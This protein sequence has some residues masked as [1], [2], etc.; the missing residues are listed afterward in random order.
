MAGLRLARSRPMSRLCTGSAFHRGFDP[1]FSRGYDPLMDPKSDRLKRGILVIAGSV[2][3]GIGI[4]GIFVPLLPTTPLLILAALCYMRGSQRLYNAL[5]G[6]RLAGSY[7][8]N[9]LEG[10]GMTLKMKIWTLT[11]L[12]VSLVLTA[13]LATGSWIIRI[14]LAVVLVGVTI[15]ILTIKT[16][17]P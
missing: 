6:N 12:W 8:R 9:Y 1:A 10:R 14:I 2:A 16:A 3:L 13:V 5:L 7:V 11:L 4:V 15:H 17:R